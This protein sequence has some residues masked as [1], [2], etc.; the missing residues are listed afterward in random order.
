MKTSKLSMQARYWLSTAILT[1]FVL[2]IASFPI[3]AQSKEATEHYVK[4]T[5]EN[6]IWGE[7]YIAEDEPI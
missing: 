3:Q 5:P 6:V 1:A 7:L 2:I 4:S